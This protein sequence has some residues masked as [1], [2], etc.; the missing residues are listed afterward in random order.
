MYE[1]RSAAAAVK[2]KPPPPLDADAIARRYQLDPMIVRALLESEG[3]PLLAPEEI[4]ESDPNGSTQVM[5]I[6][7]LAG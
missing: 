7:D 2:G 3:V 1:V 5:S 4:E 6:D